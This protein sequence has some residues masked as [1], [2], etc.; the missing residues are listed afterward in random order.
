[1]EECLSI[2]GWQTKPLPK[3]DLVDL[4]RYQLSNANYFNVFLFIIASNWLFQDQQMNI[5]LF[6][7]IAGYVR[8]G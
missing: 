2:D 4:L 6:N 1:M 3:T 8:V 7:S 5:P